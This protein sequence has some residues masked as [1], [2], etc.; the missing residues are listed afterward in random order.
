[1]PEGQV[2]HHNAGR[3]GAALTGREILRVEA[4]E[5]RMALQDPIGR[6]TGD[7]VSA[8]RAYGKHHLLELA[9]GRRLHS[10]LR[11]SGAWRVVAPGRPLRR[12]GLFLALHV[13]GAVAALYRCPMVRLL[14]PHEPLPG[15]IVALGPDLLDPGVDP[16]EATLHALRATDGGR[17]IGEALLD[18]HLVS[19]IGNAYRAET[20]FL[21]GVSPWRPV[22]TLDDDAL[23]EIGATAARLLAEGVRER[24][25]ITTHRGAAGRGG[26]W[27]HRRANRP[28]RRCGASIASR[29]QGDGNR[30]AYWCPICQT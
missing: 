19:G 17:A 28:C 6:L 7:R 20:L 1:M 10:H 14:E 21:A 16:A 26:R 29:G 22:A 13:E 4:P 2:S 5:P 23:R 24:G 30:T 25:R 9:S 12:S 27:V 8:A 18:Q 11:M 3:L 15:P